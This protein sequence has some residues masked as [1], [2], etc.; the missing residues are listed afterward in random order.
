MLRIWFPYPK[1]VLSQ[2]GVLFSKF[3]SPRKQKIWPLKIYLVP[4][5]PNICNQG[6][7]HSPQKSGL[8]TQHQVPPGIP[9]FIHVSLGILAFIHDSLGILDFI[10]D[11]LGIF[12]FIHDM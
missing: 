12:A 2:V 9:A 4:Y 3:F 5:F 1:E 11:S 6:A 7:L 10:H 8:A